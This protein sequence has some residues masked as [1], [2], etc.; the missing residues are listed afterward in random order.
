MNDQSRDEKP[1]DFN[2][3][4]DDIAGD[5]LEAGKK[6]VET[7]AGRKVAGATDTI[8][9]TAEELARKAAQSELGRKA[10]ASD[11]G[12]QAADLAKQAD[13]WTRDKIPN[14]LARNVAIGAGAGVVASLI[15]PFGAVLWGV[16]GAGLGFLRTVTKKS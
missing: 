15:L 2:Q 8:F 6:F 11:A 5:A 4:V 7:D 10:L 12:K 13:S 1:K 9:E 14:T 3:K 16:A